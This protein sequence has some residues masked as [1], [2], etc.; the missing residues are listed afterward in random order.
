MIIFQG[1]KYVDGKWGL[2]CT[3]MNPKL[4]CLE[5]ILQVLKPQTAIS[6]KSSLDPVKYQFVV[7][8]THLFNSRQNDCILNN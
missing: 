2:N 6:V 3:C 7:K 4:G 5:K 1:G 8:M